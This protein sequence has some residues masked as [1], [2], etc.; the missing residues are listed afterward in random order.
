MSVDIYL[1]SPSRCL[2]ARGKL[3]NT[4]GNIVHG[5]TLP[6][7]YVKVKIEVSIVPNAPL[8]I[9][10]EYGDVSM[11]G[12][13]IGTIVPWPLKLLQFVGECEKVNYLLST[14]FIVG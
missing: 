4:E 3:Y 6:P 14:C 12:Q 1:S 11:V 5:I 8:P 7:G 13:A 10:V 9:S 2:V